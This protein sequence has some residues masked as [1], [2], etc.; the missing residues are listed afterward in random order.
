MRDLQQGL[1]VKL[2]SIGRKI[3]L[4]LL[5]V[6]G[7]D[8]LEAPLLLKTEEQHAANAVGESGDVLV[9]TS[10]RTATSRLD[11]EIIELAV[12]CL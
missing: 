9:E 4:Q 6:P 5:S 1:R 2:G 10:W 7:A 11:L 12:M 8:D 3:C